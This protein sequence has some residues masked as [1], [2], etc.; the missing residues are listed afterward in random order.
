MHSNLSGPARGAGTTG[1]SLSVSVKAH[2]SALVAVRVN[3]VELLG[4]GVNVDGFAMA[5]SVTRV[6]G[7]Q[8]YKDAFTGALVPSCTGPLPGQNAMSGISKPGLLTVTISCSVACVA[9]DPGKMASK[10][11]VVFTTGLASG[12]AI[13]G[14]LKPVTGDH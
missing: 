11:Y 13:L 4:G 9:H 12:C 3:I 1:V 10:L 14:L 8:S 6:A 2:P 5:E 7:D